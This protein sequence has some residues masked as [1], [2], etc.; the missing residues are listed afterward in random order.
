MLRGPR[1][2]GTLG[3]TGA[4]EAPCWRRS[5]GQVSF[6]ARRL[7][8]ELTSVLTSPGNSNQCSHS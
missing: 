3:S 5:E 6:K 4:S 2:G 8:L 1:A 7:P